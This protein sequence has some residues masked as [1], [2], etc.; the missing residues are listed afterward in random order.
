MNP[1]IKIRTLSI[2]P[3]MFSNLSNFGV[4]KKAIDNKIIDFDS[5]DLRNYTDNKHKTTDKP[6]YGGGAGMVMLAKPFLDF[7]E[8]YSSQSEEKPY[9][10]LTSP[11]GKK[12]NND[13]SKRLAQK[14]NLVFI[15]PRYEGPDERVMKIVDEE[16]S[17]GDFVV[18]GGELPAM[19]MI[20]SLLRFVPQVIGDQ[21]SVIQD[22][23]YNGL[24]DYS[25]YTKP[26]N[27]NG[28]EVPEVLLS[29]NHKK[30]DL[31]RKKDSL[32]KTI[33]KRPDLFVEK[34]FSKEDKMVLVELIRELHNNAK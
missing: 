23:F 6:G 28:D 19:I 4:I 33:I 2:F 18:T 34:E 16:L 3:E 31:Y 22:S 30:I 1:K 21:D 8:D 26:N 5:I 10:I 24:L 25:H 29:G 7:Y 27:I 13:I 20:D 15:C 11:Q 14:K 12:F 32:L 9:I 17:I